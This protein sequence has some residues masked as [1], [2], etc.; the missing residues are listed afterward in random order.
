MQLYG[1]GCWL[2]HLEEKV[3]DWWVD[4]LPTPGRAGNG[5]SSQKS[6][7]PCTPHTPPPPPTIPPKNR[8]ASCAAPPLA[9][10]EVFPPGNFHFPPPPTRA[11]GASRASKPH[12][13]FP[14]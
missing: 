9:R 1:S 3:L 14:N 4:L 12:T 13:Y 7:L 6:T 10:V 2:F 8:S 11:V 5:R